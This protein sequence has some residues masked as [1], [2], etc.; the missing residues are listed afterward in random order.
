MDTDLSLGIC[1]ILLASSEGLNVACGQP[2]IISGTE[3]YI[4]KK[5]GVDPLKKDEI[6][7]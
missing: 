4:Y 6:E 7:N 2:D 3:Y 1:L 5:N